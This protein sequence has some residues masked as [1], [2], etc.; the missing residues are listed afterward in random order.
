ME[1]M[2]NANTYFIMNEA[3]IYT[4]EES[5]AEITEREVV[6]EGQVKYVLTERKGKLKTS[7]KEDK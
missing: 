2:K 5:K 1:L 6:R 3:I 7:R 4:K